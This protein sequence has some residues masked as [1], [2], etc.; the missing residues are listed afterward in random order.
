MFLFVFPHYMSN[1]IP[2]STS[3]FIT[4]SV[5][6]CVLLNLLVGDGLRSPYLYWKPSSFFASVFVSFQASQPYI[7]TDVTIVLN[8]C[9]FVFLPI[10]LVP[11]IL[12]PTYILSISRATWPAFPVS[13]IVLTF[14]FPI[15]VSSFGFTIEAVGFWV[16]FRL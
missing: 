1:P 7:K 16:S 14:Q 2:S 6:S 15:L 11:H 3:D 5:H 8:N 10:S 12:R 13:T 9:T 4:R